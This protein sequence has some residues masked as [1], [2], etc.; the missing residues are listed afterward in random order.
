MASSGLFGPYPLTGGGVSSSVKGVGPGAYALGYTDQQ[1]NTFVVQY[2][3]RS[4]DDLAKRLNDH[5]P[6]KYQQF[7]YGFYPSAKAAFDKECWLFHTFGETQLDNKIHP[8]RP[9]NQTWACPHC[10]IFG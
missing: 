1:R 4:D 8:A 9:R 3:G 7:K 10:R 2:V 5:V 6:E